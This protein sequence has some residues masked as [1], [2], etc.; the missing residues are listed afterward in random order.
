MSAVL[1]IS[2]DLMETDFIYRPIMHKNTS[3]NCR[4][5]IHEGKIV[6]I[7]PKMWM[8]NDGNYVSKHYLLEWCLMW[9]LA[10]TSSFH[11]LA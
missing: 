6:M 2:I 1:Q 8:A 5:V 9:I 7:R 4:V 3:Y 10:R 11:S